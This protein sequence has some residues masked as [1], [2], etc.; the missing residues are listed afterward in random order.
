MIPAT[1]VVTGEIPR[2]SSGK[3]DPR[4]LDGHPAIPQPVRAEDRPRTDAEHVLAAIWRD[5]L[6]VGSVG[7]QDNF[8]DLGGDSLRAVSMFTAIERRFGRKLPLSLLFAASTL[9]QLA[10]AIDVV[11]TDPFGTAAAAP[12]PRSVP[13]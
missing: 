7:I 6:G 3:L 10:A 5:V 8:F 12:R 2:T 9:E 11:L 1:I 13:M 4:R